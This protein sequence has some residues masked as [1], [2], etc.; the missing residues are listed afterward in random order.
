MA[1]SFLTRL[2]DSVAQFFLV[3]SLLVCL[4]C[5][6]PFPLDRLEEGMTTKTVRQEFGEPVETHVDRRG[7]EIW[8][9]AHEEQEWF[10]TIALHTVF[11]PHCALGALIVYPIA[12]EPLCQPYD[13]YAVILRF[14]DE[15]LMRWILMD[16]DGGTRRPP[17]G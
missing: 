8:Q 12:G 4:A 6:T 13:K 17:G 2:V 14:E 5:A 11:L 7:R 1:R 16:S 3:P 9:Y 15:K 10:T